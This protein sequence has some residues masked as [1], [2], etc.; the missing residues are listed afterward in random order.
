MKK[1]QIRTGVV[2]NVK[3]PNRAMVVLEPLEGAADGEEICEVKGA[4]PGQKISVVITK[5][6]KGKGEGRLKEI[7]EKSP[8]ETVGVENGGCPHFN[9]CGGCSYISMPY[10]ESLK[11]KEN[12]VR[13]LLEP[14]LSKQQSVC[15]IEP[16]RQSPVYY[17]YRN[18]MEFTFGD[19]VKDGPLALG[20]HKKGSFYDIVTVDG[21]RLVD[22]DYSA[23]LR[24]T[25]YYFEEKKTPFY[26]RYTHEGYL[27]HLL[28]RRASRTG[29]IL[30]ALV[31]TTQQEVDLESW[32]ER[33]LSLPLNGKFAGILHITNDS[34]SDAVKCDS[35]EILYGR[36][37]FYEELLGLKFRISTFSFF[38]T[39]TC[40]AEVLY[41][42]AREYVGSLVKEEGKPDSIV[43]DLYSGTGTIA[44]LMAP[45]AKKVIGV[46]IV[47]EAV[48]AARENAKQN[49]LENC[50]FIAGDV[51][52]VLD[53][54]EE[55]P[56]FI[57][58]DPPRDG[59]HP[60]A[61][62]RIIGYGVEKLVYI[63]CKPTSLARDLEIFIAN[64]YEV[65]RCVPVDQ[66][67][68]T[69]G[70][71]TVVLLSHKK[72][73]SYI[74][75]DVEFGEGEGKI[76]VDSIAKRAEAYKPKEKVT[77]KMIKEYIEAKYGFKVHTA[78][79][80]EVK[81][82]LGLPMYDA[83]NAVEELKQPR[84]HTTPEKVE[85]IKDALRYF[86]VI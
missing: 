30:A 74:H 59:V 39:N 73:D 86:A 14:V 51:L 11:I 18:K 54:I 40:G 65:Q 21:C 9:I 16:I 31:T 82:D 63:S 13:E 85:A 64:G 67:P 48:V 1:G 28:V 68:W 17:G 79:I 20:M 15:Q 47:E 24:E 72:A 25:L 29:E 43:Y 7:L 44:Q 35:S 60:K 42:T 58:L 12:Q 32:K 19:E 49:G 56:D 71:E 8:I 84:K 78:Y 53:E 22:D 34:M 27:R 77:Y 52:K 46:E 23:I 2:R 75:I 70:I 61:L 10:E 36:D 55:K 38:Q 76:P 3:F 45:V 62:S 4:L 41:E 50:E 83:P 37:Y 5:V 57:I 6:R 81:R 69:T 66:F 33:L 80:A 26:H